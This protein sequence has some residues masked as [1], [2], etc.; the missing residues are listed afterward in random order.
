VFK[1]NVKDIV[2]IKKNFPNLS[3][4]KVKEIYKVLNMPRKNKHRINMITKSLSRRQV[5]VSITLTNVEKFIVLSGKHV[6]SINR[7]FKDI[8]SDIM[9]DFIQADFKELTITTNKVAFIL[10]LNMIE[11]YIKNVDYV[12]SDN[13]IALRLFQV[14]SKDLRNSI[15]Y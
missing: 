2:K 11:K 5:L 7:A 6:A 10:D 9:A 4:K 8:K 13:I 1:S 15:S 12:D 3:I 14:L